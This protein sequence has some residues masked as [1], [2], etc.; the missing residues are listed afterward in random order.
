MKYH[1]IQHHHFYVFGV[2]VLYS[3]NNLDT[4]LNFRMSSFYKHAAQNCMPKIFRA[5]ELSTLEKAIQS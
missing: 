3:D 1:Q 4:G 2:I 5:I